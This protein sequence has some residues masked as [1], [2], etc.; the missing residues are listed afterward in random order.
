[1]IKNKYL[2][3]LEQVNDGFYDTYSENP[4]PGKDNLENSNLESIDAD[5]T[6]EKHSAANMDP[7]RNYLKDMGTVDVLSKEDEVKI[8]KEIEKLETDIKKELAKLYITHAL[9]EESIQNIFIEKAQIQDVIRYSADTPNPTN[10]ETVDGFWHRNKH[11]NE[12]EYHQKT[13]AYK[14]KLNSLKDNNLIEKLNVYLANFS[15]IK[16][17]SSRENPMHRESLNALF[18]EFNYTPKYLRILIDGIQSFNREFDSIKLD[19]LTQINPNKSQNMSSREL[20]NKFLYAVDHQ[21]TQLFIDC[22]SIYFEAN[23]N[24]IN[25]TLKNAKALKNDIGCSLQLFSEVKTRLF[26]LTT[27]LGNKKNHFVEANLRLVVS[28]AKK[29]TH[30]GLQFLDLIQEGNLG[31]MRAAEKF[32]YQRGFK[33]ST[34]AT[35]WIRQAI[36]R[37]ISDQTRTIRLP[38]H[39][40]ERQGKMN[41]VMRK[42]YQ[43][44]GR[45]PNVN[46][47]SSLLEVSQEKVKE[48]INV[49]TEPISSDLPTGKEKSSTISELLS[50]PDEISLSDITFSEEIASHIKDKLK[51]LTIREQKILTLR[52][53][54]G[55]SS[56]LTLEQIGQ[57]FNVTRERIRQIETVA[58]T[59]LRENDELAVINAISNN[60][61]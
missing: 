36:S 16:E 4:T 52:F 12:E 24:K 8:G 47:L 34:Y 19:F 51:I 7:I 21:E 6:E 22:Y 42:F 61:T 10:R 58:L 13:E 17:N 26:Y 60:N 2:G 25:K 44:H 31:L 43:Q 56:A 3:Y 29:Y 48:T 53:G 37:A 15:V 11:E 20:F 32:E 30:R 1:M 39:M 23:R 55:L 27:L 14:E 49:V 41:R 35:W 18:I 54:I 28:I 46:E 40:S 45:E 59:K 33:F 9:L 50:N 5:E 38:A 57:L